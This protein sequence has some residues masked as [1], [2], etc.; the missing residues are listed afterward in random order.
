MRPGTARPEE[1]EAAPA[2]A[3]CAARVQAKRAHAA[4]LARQLAAARP[5][6]VPSA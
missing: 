5:A 3:A 4:G 6:A 1:G 2:A